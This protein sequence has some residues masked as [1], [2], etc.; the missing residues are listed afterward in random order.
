MR[1][2]KQIAELAATKAGESRADWHRRRPSWLIQTALTGASA[3]LLDYPES[4]II[5][6]LAIA[7][8]LCVVVVEIS[9]RWHFRKQHEIRLECLQAH[10]QEQNT[11]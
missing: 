1:T 3:M 4:L 6:G 9:D 8:I 2:Y 10:E 7:C 5:S 11:K